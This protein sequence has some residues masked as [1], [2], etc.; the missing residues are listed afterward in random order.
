MQK[1]SCRDLAEAMGIS[2]S[3]AAEIL[4]LPAAPDPSKFINEASYL[5]K[6]ARCAIKAGHTDAALQRLAL[7]GKRPAPPEPSP[8]PPDAPQRPARA[9]AAPAEGEPGNDVTA[10]DLGSA[11]ATLRDLVV[12]IGADLA[13]AVRTKRYGDVAGLLNQFRALSQEFRQ[14]VERLEGLRRERLE[15]LP[16]TEVYAAAGQMFQVMRAFGD[17]IMGDLLNAGNLP[18]WIAARG[19]KFP[20]DLE[21]VVSI[22][23]TMREWAVAHFNRLA[24][25]L[26]DCAVPLEDVSPDI[27]EQ[28]MV[29]MADELE[30]AA[31]G[32]RAR[33]V[34]R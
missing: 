14:T 32:L 22:R 4:A 31:S 23:G 27:A 17:A 13:D 26:Q 19:G 1:P 8:D 29:E 10:D 24:D 25:T 34:K 9:P 12:G 28:C 20:D 5:K 18:A 2:K 15:H 11:A 3:L 7:G 16:R 33:A 6:L 21:S 30:K